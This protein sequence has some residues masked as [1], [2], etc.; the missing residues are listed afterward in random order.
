MVLSPEKGIYPILVT[1]KIQILYP[2]ILCPRYLLTNKYK[3]FKNGTGIQFPELPRLMKFRCNL[4]CNRRYRSGLTSYYGP[5]EI[6]YF[7]E[8]LI[9]FACIPAV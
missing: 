1:N 2:T 7:L 3:N 5:A 9:R 8:V 4:P 6:R